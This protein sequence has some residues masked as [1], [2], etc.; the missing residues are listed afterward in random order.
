MVKKT[1]LLWYRKH[2]LWYL[3]LRAL[4][5][6][7]NNCVQMPNAD[8]AWI[9]NRIMSH[10][11]YYQDGPV[12]LYYSGCQAELENELGDAE[13]YYRLAVS[14]DPANPIYIQAA[15]R[16]LHRRGMVED[17]KGLYREAIACMGYKP[18]CA[19]AMLTALVCGALGER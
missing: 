5:R 19:N 15:A 10:G 14:Q 3:S 6:L 12:Q 16:I 4:G 18:G 9:K 8:M 17:A 2:P 1:L 7:R 13:K 11:M